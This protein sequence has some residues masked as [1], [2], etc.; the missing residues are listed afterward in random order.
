[1]RPYSAVVTHPISRN[2]KEGKD[3]SV[4]IR[5]VPKG[6]F[7]HK[8]LRSPPSMASMLGKTSLKVLSRSGPLH[9]ASETAILSSS[10]SFSS[11]LP[12]TNCPF[13][14][15]KPFACRMIRSDHL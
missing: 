10:A 3:G 4:I 14:C 13:A 15:A 7:E 11:V 6:K 12:P 5:L 1:M 9:N 2:E 8:Y